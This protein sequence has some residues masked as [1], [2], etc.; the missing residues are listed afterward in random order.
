MT[1]AILTVKV[2]AE[3]RRTA[4][5]L[6]ATPARAARCV[7]AAVAAAFA[8]REYSHV[9]PFTLA[10]NR[11][12]VFYMCKDM[13]CK[14]WWVKCVPPVPRIRRR[15]Q[16]VLWPSHCG[17]VWCGVVW[18]GCHA[19]AAVDRYAALPVYAVA[20]LHLYNR[21]CTYGQRRT[22]FA[23]VPLLIAGTHSDTAA[24]PVFGARVCALLSRGCH[25]SLV[26]SV[27]CGD[28]PVPR[29]CTPGGVRYHTRGG[30]SPG[31]LT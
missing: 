12:F 9:H 10:D 16:R 4:C 20:L 8:V 1:L 31:A 7:V 23:A 29:S 24:L 14:W 11:H 27:R 25:C 5:T 15:C 13:C 30:G 28:D 18:C 21:M 3:L 26:A 19:V 2:L 22:H 17:V 6:V